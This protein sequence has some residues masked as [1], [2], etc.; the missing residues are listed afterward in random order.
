MPAISE[1]VEQA[2]EEKIT[3]LPSW[4][5]HRVLE[6]DG[7][8]TGMELVRCTAVFDKDGR[9]APTF[10]TTVK[11]VVAADQ[12]LVA[13]GQAADL[14]YAEPWLKPERGLLAADKVTGA[15]AMPGVFAGGDV[16]GSSATMV[17]AMASGQRAAASIEAY[18]AR[19]QPDPARPNHVPLIIN[20]AALPASQRVRA[21][22]LPVG[23]RTLLTEDCGA[24]S[25]DMLGCEATRCANCGCVAVSA[26][27]LAPALIALRATVKTT[28]QRLPPRVSSPRQRARRRSWSRAS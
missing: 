6:Q 28:R 9:F 14:S 21:P 12:I 5:P 22:R 27:D 26:S 8:L 10:N 19:V 18:F 2:L 4:G 3:I 11:K 20:Q 17:Q 7:K 24:L 23:Q 13:I 16:T 1:D 25:H 15:T